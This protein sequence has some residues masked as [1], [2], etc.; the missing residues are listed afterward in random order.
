MRINSIRSFG[1]MNQRTQAK[2]Q[3]FGNAYITLT[4]TNLADV[5][6]KNVDAYNKGDFVKMYNSSRESAQKVID[7]VNSTLKDNTGKIQTV[8]DLID[9]TDL[10]VLAGGSGSRFR[11]MAAAIADLRGKGESFNKISVPFELEDKQTPLTMLDIPMAM[12][13]FFAPKTGYEKII[14]EKPSGSFGDVVKNYLYGT[15]MDYPTRAPRDVVVCCGDNVF[16]M[17]SEDLLRYIVRTIN[18]PKKQLGVVG[19][20]R[21]PEEVAGRFGVLAVGE[22]NQDTG[23]FPLKGFVEKPALDKAKDL[24]TPQGDCIANTGMFVIKKDS[25][26]KLVDI[27]GHEMRTLGGKSFYIAKNEKEPFDFAN[28]TKWTRNLNGDDASDVLMVKTW[29]DVG[30]PQAYQRWAQQLKQGHYLG[31]FTPERRDAILKAAKY[32]VTD[33]SIQFSLDSKGETVID[34]INI[35]A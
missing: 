34:D 16:D 31:N 15:S 21:T 5:I 27:I 23:L 1:V 7:E 10:Y 13:R 25:M 24:A 26:E 4:A 30:E 12:G 8:D 28:A 3:S 20:A 17:K 2:K 18:D 22:Q 35:K 6:S 14:A 29:E 11:P 19:V 32:R 33:N 9:K